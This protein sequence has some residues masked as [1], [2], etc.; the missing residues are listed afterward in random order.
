MIR[1]IIILVAGLTVYLFTW[2]TGLTP[3]AWTP[4]P[5]PS[6]TDGPFA[7]NDKLRGVGRLLSGFGKGPE[8]VAIGPDQRLYAGFA[9][10]RIVSM[11]ADGDDCR[12]LG[13]TGGRPLGLHVDENGVVWIADPKQG[14][15]RLDP[16]ADAE[17]VAD[18]ADGIAMKF[19][20]DLDEDGNGLIYLSDASHKFGYGEHMREALEHGGNGRLIRYHKDS[21]RAE[22]L[23]AGLYFANG[24]A[25]GP[26]DEYVLV[27]ETTKYRILKY[28]LKGDK[29]GTQ[30]V[31][32]DNLPGFPGNL[33]FNGRDRIWVALFAPRSSL[34]DWSLPKPH[35]RQIIARLPG[36]LQP[37]LANH[38]IVLGIDLDGEVV[39]NYQFDHRSAYAPVTSVEEHQGRLYLGSLS[40][41]GIGVISLN[42]LRAGA[43]RLQA[44]EPSTASCAQ[45]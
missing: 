4:P 44:P 45:H 13:Q 21:G 20:D 40:A 37:G 10:G 25:L 7:S 1:P 8:G 2:N 42:A 41:D 43:E 32:I 23:M 17:R 11:S 31:W 3:K 39:E 35:I 36:F 38:A 26:D 28:W 5:A 19:A 29:A 30:E 9:D 27:A 18:G 16:G 34:L 14:L 22:T 6:T 33:S 12:I 24:V 15:M